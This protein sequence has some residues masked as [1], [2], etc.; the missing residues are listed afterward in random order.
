M[1]TIALK[2]CHV[3]IVVK[4][5]ILL[6]VPKG[7][8]IAFCASRPNLRAPG[9]FFSGQAGETSKASVGRENSMGAVYWIEGR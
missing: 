5:P 8:N 3:F 9:D 7:K 6:L 1:I 4:L 2:K